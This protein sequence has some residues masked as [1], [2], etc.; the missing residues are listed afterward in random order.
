MFTYL[1]NLSDYFPPLLI[2]ALNRNK[3]KFLSSFLSKWIQFCKRETL[4]QNQRDKLHS[5]MK[6]RRCKAA[7]VWLSNYSKQ[8]INLRLG[9]ALFFEYQTRQLKGWAIDKLVRKSAVQ[10]RKRMLKNCLQGALHRS[11]LKRIME[12][13]K[14]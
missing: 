7:L 4:L 1:F 5:N 13:W 8:K 6:K 10:K 11:T 9:K 12:N 14:W 2:L 3:F